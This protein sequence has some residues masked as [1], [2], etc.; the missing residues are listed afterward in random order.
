MPSYDSVPTGDNKFIEGGNEALIV[1]TTL[2][3]AETVES[4]EFL[5]LTLQLVD[6]VLGTVHV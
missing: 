1:N 3:I 6:G 4:A 5:I 2:L